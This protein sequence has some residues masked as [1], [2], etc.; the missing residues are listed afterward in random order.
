AGAFEPAAA[1][2]G[3]RS[4]TRSEMA[5]VVTTDGPADTGTG[6]SITRVVQAPSAADATITARVAF[7]AVPP[8]AGGPP[9]VKLDQV[10]PV[11]VR[12]A[13]LQCVS[14]LQSRYEAHRTPLGSLLCEC[15]SAG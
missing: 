11:S 6:R 5:G 7:I 3:P 1:A 9:S 10:P 8:Q 2:A 4:T 12:A 14:G 13:K 15:G